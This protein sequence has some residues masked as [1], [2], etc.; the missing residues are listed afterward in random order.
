MSKDKKKSRW[1][2]STTTKGNG[3]GVTTV[4]YPATS[5][6]K[7]THFKK[8]QRGDKVLLIANE[9]HIKFHLLHSV[10]N[11]EWSGYGPVEQV[12]ENTYRLID[13]YYLSDDDHGGET[14]LPVEATAQAWMRVI[15]AGIE[16]EKVQLAWVHCH[17]F[18]SAYWSSIDEEAILDLK[19]RNGNGIKQISVLFYGDGTMARIDGFGFASEDMEVKVSYG[20]YW[21]DVKKA[22]ELEDQHKLRLAAVR[23]KAKESAQKVHT[24]PDDE[25]ES[26]GYPFQFGF[27]GAYDWYDDAW[28]GRGVREEEVDT[29]V[30]WKYQC[31]LC[32]TEITTNVKPWKCLACGHSV[33]SRCRSEYFKNVCLVCAFDVQTVHEASTQMGPIGYCHM[34]GEETERGELYC[35]EH[36]RLFEDFSGKVGR[37]R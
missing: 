19:S 25:Y 6:V 4:V 11:L 8:L 28:A 27:S 9:A 1:K 21:P 20:P 26:Y 35:D 10:T 18:G 3:K 22:I 13:F 14:N 17:P 23:E 37:Y 16:P 5:S 15:E 32:K 34:C 2:A 36:K 24:Y 30:T 33:C 12:D 7:T 31:E 29:G